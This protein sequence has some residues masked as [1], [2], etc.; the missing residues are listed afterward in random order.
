[1]T[2]NAGYHAYATGDV[3]TAAQVQ[4]NLQ[5]QTVMYFATTTARDA[6]LTGAILV[7]GMVSYT[8]ATGVMYYNGTAWTAVGSS[9][10]LT[11][12][13]DLYTYSTTNARLPVGSDGQIL[14]ADS[15]ATTGLRYQSTMAAGKNCVINGGFDIWQR[16]TSTTLTSGQTSFTSDRWNSY[17]AGATMTISRQATSDT[18]N[19]PSIQYCYRLSRASGATS[20]G[21]L[22][23]ANS[24][25]TVNSIPFA[26]KA[27]TFS[28]YARKGANYSATASALSATLYSGTGTDQNWLNVGYTGQASVASGTA[29]LTTTW[30]RFSYTGI[31]D[32]TATELTVL[33]NFTPTGTAGAADYFEVTGVQV[34][35]GSVATQFS[36][37][38]GNIQGELAACQRYYIRTLSNQLSANYGFG[39]GNTTTQAYIQVPIAEM[40]IAPTT[41]DYSTL[42][43]S[44]GT[45]GAAVT[46]M[47]ISAGNS[48]PRTA[49]LVPVT[50]GS[51]TA[52]RPYLLRNN[53][54]TSGYLGLGAEL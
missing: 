1:M 3:L 45:S 34:E 4:Y 18:T 5:N 16:G 51:V 54:S 41:V 40:R 27:V 53:A 24:F 48:T 43:V 32:A 44:D 14:V 31:V 46:S 11:T 47:T 21:I 7:E 2:A 38:G 33:F 37:A 42:E 25:E 50:A 17:T 35:V 36:R 23:S 49:F 13:G 30:Q 19:L 20:T 15:S 52:L 29:T 28:F 22:Y 12:K 39:I 9:S 6:A 26:G 8:P 10:P